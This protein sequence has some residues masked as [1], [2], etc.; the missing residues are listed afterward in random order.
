MAL[1][2]KIKAKEILVTIEGYGQ[3]WHS[4]FRV[5]DIPVLYSPYM[6]FP[7]KTKRQSGLLLPEPGYSSR[8]GLTFNLPF[9]WAISDNTDA[10]FNEYFMSRRGFMQGAEF[11]YALSPFS[12]GTL[13]LDYLF[14]DWG[15]EEQYKEGNISKPYTERYWFRSKINQ[16]LPWDMD[17]KMDLDLVSDRDYLNEFQ[18]TPNGLNRNRMTFLSD[19]NRDLGDQTQLS[20]TNAA[21]LT[22]NF[23]SYSFTG[24]FTFYQELADITTA[25][26][27]LP[28]ARFDGIKQVLWKD[29][30]YQ[31]GSSYN[32]YWA[33]S[34]DSGHVVELTPTLYYPTKFGNYLKLEGS[35]GV[36]EDLYQVDN[37][38]SSSVDSF[39]NR[40]VPSL[41]LDMSTDIE[42]IY[43]LSGEGLQK[44]K[45]T[46]RPQIVYNYTPEIAQDRLPSFISAISQNNT[47]TYYLYNTF[48]GK[49]LLGKGSQGEDLFGY[50]DLVQLKLYQSYALSPGTFTTHTNIGATPTTITTNTNIN[51]TT[52]TTTTNPGGTTTTTT[53]P[54]LSDV[55]GEL[56][57]TPHP[58]LSLRSSVAWSP[59]TGQIDS[60]SY[61]LT[62][63]DKKGNRAYLEYLATMGDQIR[64]INANLTWKISSLW[65]ANFLTSYSLDQNINY[66]TGV[67]VTYT[68]QCWGIRLS[69]WTNPTDTSFMIYFTLKGLG[70]F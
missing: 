13:M 32:Y 52:I 48:T 56:E 9:F 37:K 63:F 70:E 41:R 54:S 23:G 47:V 68:K 26:D 49:S 59:Y 67:G 46:I 65:S 6:I 12:K 17:L 5:R 60:Q 61:N 35:M 25:L 11:R 33:K 55:T 64:Q 3:V 1:K 30:Y 44:L 16:R 57:L 50:R 21:V 24:G 43:Q 22:K 31:W 18:A 4:S 66:G 62:L 58:N 51:G 14:K 34:S 8:D 39:G 2:R 27:Q 45:H 53:T 7:A 19:F 10:T 20:R 29:L 40:S 15:S 69:Y 38:I 28:Y 36:T 42:K